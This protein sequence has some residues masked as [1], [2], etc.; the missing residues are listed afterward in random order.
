MKLLSWNVNGIRAIAKKNFVQTIRD[1]APDV[2]CL[3]EIKA[4]PEMVTEVTASL[5]GYS[6][7]VNPA[8]KKGYSGTAILSREKPL[9]VESGPVGEPFLPE[10]RIQCAEYEDFYL[11]NVY[12]PNSGQGLKRLGYRESWD[13]AFLDYLKE[14]HGK[15]PVIVCGDMNVA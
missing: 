4:G 7:F 9:S 11:V 10:G 3:Q 8:E 12:V 5:D 15:K 1:L 13:A 6:V 2:L 14:L